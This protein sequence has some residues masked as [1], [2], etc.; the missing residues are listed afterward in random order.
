MTQR[1]RLIVAMALT[2]F[3]YGMLL[4]TV[5]TVILRAQASLGVAKAQ[6]GNFD[7]FKDLSIMVVSCICA[8]YL[9]R[10]GLKRAMQAGLFLS[11][12]ACVLMRIL[13]AYATVC[14]HYMLIGASFPFIKV[15]IYTLI[16][17]VTDDAKGHASLTSVIEGCF[18]AGML[19][20]PL[21]FSRFVGDGLVDTSYDWLNAYWIFAGLCALCLVVLSSAKIDETRQTPEGEAQ[22]F[23]EMIKL[24]RLPLVMVFIFSAFVYVVIEQGIN[25]WLP[26]F[27]NEVLK[28][29]QSMSVIAGSFLAA[30]IAVGRLVGA[31][32][33]RK[34]GWYPIVNTCLA[35]VFCAIVA[36]APL[37]QMAGHAAVAGWLHAPLAAYLF[38]AI[39]AFMGPIY[40]T[41]V[42][43]LLS[44]SPKSRHIQLMGL[45]VIFSAL[46]GS[47]GAKL[48]ATLLTYFSGPWAFTPMV[49]PAAILG[50]GVTLLRRQQ[51]ATQPQIHV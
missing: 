3:T 11:G 9:P 43:V 49:I 38:L 4:N 27:D 15:G 6:A 42:S 21:L 29:P 18:G 20:V 36:I 39:G 40:P 51:L 8:S 14:L 13:P 45:V 17:H 10:I 26:T 25:N 46:G 2:Y 47:A 37:S 44:A 41:I 23:I 48:A 24:V 32:F 28:L 12:L 5:G 33:I 7:P 19:S 1:T 34:F 35:L 22:S 16:G 31:G 50:V 30:S